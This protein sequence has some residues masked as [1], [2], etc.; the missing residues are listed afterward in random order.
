MKNVAFTALVLCSLWIGCNERETAAPDLWRPLEPRLST[1]GQWR[2]CQQQPSRNGRAVKQECGQQ[3]ERSA[4]KCWFIGNSPAKAERVLI[5]QPH[6]ID[7]VVEAFER[8]S[9]ADPRFHADSA[10][11]YYVRAQREDS[12]ADLLSALEA[13]DRAVSAAPAV[14]AGHFNYALTLQEL[15]LYGQAMQSWDAFL[16]LE[17]Q[18]GWAAEARAHRRR[19]AALRPEV[20]E[21][22]WNRNRARIPAALQKRDVDEVLQLIALYPQTALQYFEDELLPQWSEAPTAENLA[23]ARVYAQALSRRFAGDR[24]PEEAVE[25]ITRAAQSPEKLRVL[26]DAH[27]IY[28]QQ[29]RA[30][31]P[32]LAVAVQL[33]E[34]AGSPFAAVARQRHVATVAAFPRSRDEMT[35][36]ADEIATAL[37]HAQKHHYFY[38]EQRLLSTSALLEWHKSTYVQS[39]G[40]YEAASHAIQRMRDYESENENLFRRSGVT[41]GVGLHELAFEQTLQAVRFPRLI[42]WR[43]RHLALGEASSVARTLDRNGAA[44]HY[45][46]A[47]VQWLEDHLKV[48]DAESRAYLQY[49][50][51]TALRHRAD[52]RFRLGEFPAGQ[53]DLRRAIALYEQHPDL[54][55]G[56]RARIKDVQA[57]GASSAAAIRLLTEALH[58]AKEEP[59]TVRA[60]LFARRAD[61]Y[62]K[63]GQLTKAKKDLTAA[64]ATVR[65]EEENQLSLRKIGEAESFWS[66]YFSRFKETYDQ[67]ILQLVAE[68]NL[69]GAFDY[70]ERSRAYEPLNL[71]ARRDDTPDVFRTILSRRAVSIADLQKHIP[72][73]TVVLEYSV[74]DDRAFC[75]ILSRDHFDMLP[76]PGLSRERLEGWS[77]RV[78]R[79]L[80]RMDGPEIDRVMV[81]PYAELLLPALQRIERLQGGRKPSRIVIV[82]DEAMRGLPLVAAIH[83]KSH[84][85]L[86]EYAP[87]AFSGSATL[88]TYSVLRSNALWSAEPWSML[89]IGY[90]YSARATELGLDPLPSAVHEVEKIE[91][92]HN[93]P[94]TKLIG[95]DATRANFLHHAPN[96]QII[97]FAGHSVVDRENPF[98]SVLLFATDTTN[99]GTFAADELLTKLRLGQ[100]ILFVLASCESADDMP[101]GPEG[102]APLVRPVIAAGVPAIV[103]SL[104]DTMDATTTP[105]LVSFYDEYRRSGD[106]AASLQ[107]A[108]LNALRS[109]NEWRQSVLAW[110]AFQVIGHAA[111]PRTAGTINEKEKPP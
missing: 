44:L 79:A 41:R 55:P 64:L 15:G 31:E 14:A 33:F 35:E 74:F 72:E 19:I 1:T 99:D 32:D 87:I 62:R 80:R 105:L 26:C 109:G 77:E 12:V 39:V 103:G 47:A 68:G 85:R 86:I 95:T 53:I 63:L 98:R 60:T 38:L 18:G 52:I 3:P 69:H 36:I 66:G 111:P 81:A 21:E 58:H 23:R 10:A 92:S 110:G 90:P 16:K 20:Y 70:V 5:E 54:I 76:L 101:A 84:K 22:E 96:H 75:W 43:N 30:V 42:H 27:A 2:E 102:V 93:G 24:M 82:R 61:A 104:W 4:D 9:R 88:Y 108:Q 34:R 49:N 40:I 28:R 91:R 83:P 100:T 71:I 37:R 97:H 73:G 25:A 65:A 94:A 45:Q 67:L 56:L 107:K 13:G 89:L 11:A 50:L 17:P 7:D 106:A 48:A 8:F 59:P 6:C 51:A 46:D 78:Q 57:R 29:R